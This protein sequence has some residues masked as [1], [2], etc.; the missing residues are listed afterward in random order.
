MADFYSANQ[1]LEEDDQLKNNK[2][3]HFDFYM[4]TASDESLE[5]TK[6][7]LLA[8]HHHVTVV[9]TGAEALETIKKLI[10]EGVTVAN[11]GSTTLKQI[12]YVDY[13]KTT[14]QWKD[15]TAEALSHKDM[16][17][18]N[19]LRRKA[20]TADYFVSSVTALAE[21]GELVSG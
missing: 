9:N 21:T 3:L 11:G 7:A 6:A 2:N 8:K 19:D 5:R 4:K 13:A 1:L 20:T 18:V 15:L 12:G 14:K 17:T 10:P 16:A